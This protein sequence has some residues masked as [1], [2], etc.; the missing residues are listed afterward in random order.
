MACMSFLSVGFRL[1]LAVHGPHFM[2]REIMT[3]FG[4]SG[5]DNVSKSRSFQNISLTFRLGISL[6]GKANCRRNV[7]E[8]S[9]LLS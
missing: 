5:R 6:L 7:F 4:R 9:D 2:K 8:P 1:E 3:K